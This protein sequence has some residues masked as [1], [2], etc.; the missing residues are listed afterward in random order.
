MV[1]QYLQDEY[2]PIF[3]INMRVIDKFL[4]K[5]FWEEYERKGEIE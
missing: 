1:E 3:N 4:V 2:E 5:E